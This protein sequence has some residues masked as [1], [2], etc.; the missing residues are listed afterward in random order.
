[1]WNKLL[2][3]DVLVNCMMNVATMLF[4]PGLLKP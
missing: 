1:M 3:M 4:N 2:R